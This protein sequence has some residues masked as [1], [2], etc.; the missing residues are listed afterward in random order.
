MRL[1]FTPPFSRPVCVWPE[2]ALKRA[3]QQIF[4]NR[5]HIPELCLKKK[6]K[7]ENA[8]VGKDDGPPQCRFDKSEC[9]LQPLSD[10]GEVI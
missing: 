5:A 6:K 8:R 2:G 4:L 3:E 7:R 1:V 9:Q 10:P